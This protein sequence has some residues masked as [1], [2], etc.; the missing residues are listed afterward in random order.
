MGKTDYDMKMFEN[1]TGD[2]Q[3]TLSEPS[4]EKPSAE[5]KS[6]FIKDSSAENSFCMEYELSTAQDL[7][8]KLDRFLS[9]KTCH[10]M[11]RTALIRLCV[12]SCFKY[13]GQI[14]LTDD[15]GKIS[16]FIYEF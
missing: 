9:L 5:M 4:W 2:L 16:E 10:E 12:A 13:A 8:D 11:K 7:Y 14:Q 3:K 1:L 15:S 6:Y